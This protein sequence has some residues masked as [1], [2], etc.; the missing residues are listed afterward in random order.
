M[1]IEGLLSID[2][3]AQR[4]GRSPQAVRQMAASGE[5]DAVRRGRQWWLDERAVERRRREPRGRGRALSP[6][7]AWSVLFLASGDRD[8]ARRVAAER[9]SPHGPR[10]GYAITSYQ[11]MLR[12]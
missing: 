6:E 9:T 2:E 11:L 10:V 4:L 1:R 5:L 7:V 12:G 3:A 8:R